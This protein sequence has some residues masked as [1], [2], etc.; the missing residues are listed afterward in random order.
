[1]IILR[2]DK[3]KLRLEKRFRFRLSDEFDSGQYCALAAIL[4]ATLSSKTIEH[5]PSCYSHNLT[6]YGTDMFSIIIRFS[7]YLSCFADRE[8][9]EDRERKSFKKLDETQREIDSLK[10]EIRAERKKAKCLK[11]EQFKLF[12][13]RKS[14]KAARKQK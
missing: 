12:H 6:L 11:R 5:I 13:E 9:F 8:T 1:M 14:V 7:F 2:N 10:K 4:F 3:G